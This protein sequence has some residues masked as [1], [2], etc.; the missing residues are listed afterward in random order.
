MCSDNK[1][2]LREFLDNLRKPGPSAHKAAK[3]L[4]NNLLKINKLQSCCGNH[5]QPGC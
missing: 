5:G 1:P 2:D 3:F 4:R